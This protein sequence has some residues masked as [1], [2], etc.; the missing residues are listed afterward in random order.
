FLYDLWGQPY[1][2]WLE[3][4]QKGDIDT[5]VDITVGF[6]ATL[7]W[8]I[9]DYFY[10]KRYETRHPELYAKERIESALQFLREVSDEVVEGRKTVRKQWV[11]KFLQPFLPK[12]RKGVN[13]LLKLLDKISGNGKS[14]TS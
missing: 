7:L 2:Y 11:A 12:I 13:D 5:M 8:V 10:N 3:K 14:D 9:G 1:L 6:A 4:A